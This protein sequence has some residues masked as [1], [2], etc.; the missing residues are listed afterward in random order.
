MK[1]SIFITTGILAALAANAGDLTRAEID[2]KLKKLADTPPPKTLETVA[3]CYRAAT[4]PARVEYVCPTCGTRILISN[5]SK[6]PLY[7]I[8]PN[9]D[10]YRRQTEELRKLGLN[11]T[12]DETKLCA[13]CKGEKERGIELNWNITINGTE[14]KV[15]FQDNDIN[16][17]REFLKDNNKVDNRPSNKGSFG[18][19]PLKNYL[20]RLNELVGPQK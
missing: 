9:L 6:S 14:R 7:W 10:F 12:L 15:D 2:A 3:K 17:L 20:P 8:L 4:P 19:Q 13:K 18:E 16:L 1:K 5:D 11:I